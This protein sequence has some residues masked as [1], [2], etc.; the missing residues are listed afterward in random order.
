ME[1]TIFPELNVNEKKLILQNTSKM[2]NM[3]LFLQHKYPNFT[4]L[5]GEWVL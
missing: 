4:F 2:R 1:C 5:N 3:C